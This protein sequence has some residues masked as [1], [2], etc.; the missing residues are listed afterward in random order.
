MNRK[1][2]FVL[3]NGLFLI[4]TFL[5]MMA[6]SYGGCNALILNDEQMT[7]CYVKRYLFSVPAILSALLG[8]LFVVLGFLEPKKEVTK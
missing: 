4:G 2:W 5:I 7:A 6:N 8:G 3:G 1:Q